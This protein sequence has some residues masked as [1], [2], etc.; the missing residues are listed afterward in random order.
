MCS[1]RKSAIVLLGGKK[2]FNENRSLVRVFFREK[3]ATLHWLSL[4]PWRPLPPNAERTTVFCIESVE[5]TTLGPEMQHWALDSLGCFLV[6]A[7]V[8]DI[9]RCRG[10]IFLADSMNASG[11]AIRRDIFV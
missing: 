3:V 9:N 1:T 2:L 5:R 10:A 6:G 11:I 4:R 7:I 8:F